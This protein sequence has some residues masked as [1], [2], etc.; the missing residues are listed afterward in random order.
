MR[1]E[2]AASLAAADALVG[3][4]VLEDLLKAEEL[5]DAGIDGG[6]ESQPALVGAERGVELD[7]EAAV[8]VDRS[9]VVHPRHAEHDL[10]LRLDDA[11]QEGVL[12]VVGVLGDDGIQ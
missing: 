3:Q 11:L 7:A 5:D 4:G 6:V 1:V 9:G 12:G 8:D 10:A 2:V